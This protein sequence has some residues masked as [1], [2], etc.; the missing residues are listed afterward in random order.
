[1]ETFFKNAKKMDILLKMNIIKGLEKFNE[2]YL[3]SFIFYEWKYVSIPLIK[4]NSTFF[5]YLCTYIFI[6]GNLSNN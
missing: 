5:T 1:M 6:S 2:N 4:V 3:S